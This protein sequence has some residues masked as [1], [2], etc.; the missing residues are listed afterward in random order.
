VSSPVS[1]LVRL[2]RLAPPFTLGALVRLVLVK[3]PMPTNVRE[4]SDAVFFTTRVEQPGGGPVDLTGASLS[5]VLV[6]PGGDRVAAQ[7]EAEDAPGGLVR[8]ETPPGELAGAG[9]WRVQ[10]SASWSD[11]GTLVTPPLAVK[12]AP[13]L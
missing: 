7:A 6:S 2:A 8:V 5:A 1:P 4:R 12:A 11:G 9:R 10:V 3:A 13:V